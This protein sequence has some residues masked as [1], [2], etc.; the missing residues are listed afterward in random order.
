[1]E[2]IAQLTS[3]PEK[4]DGW[5]ENLRFSI[6]LYWNETNLE[7]VVARNEGPDHRGARP[8]IWLSSV[9]TQARYALSGWPKR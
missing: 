2:E 4:H 9:A 8:T 1:M 5:L 7:E 3:S 6:E